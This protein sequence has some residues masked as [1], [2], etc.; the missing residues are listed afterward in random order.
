MQFLE[1]EQWIAARNIPPDETVII[2][3]DMNVDRRGPEWL[4]MLATLTYAKSPPMGGSGLLR[5]A[6]PEDRGPYACPSSGHA[7][8]MLPDTP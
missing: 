1:I 2:G 4:D 5:R 3:G 8:M 7:P 6:R